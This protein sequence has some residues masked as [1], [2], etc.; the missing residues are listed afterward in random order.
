MLGRE[1]DPG[2][3]GAWPPE[4]FVGTTGWGVGS[5]PQRTG[6]RS[7]LGGKKVK[8]RKGEPHFTDEQTGLQRG[9][10]MTSSWGWYL[11]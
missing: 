5:K 10:D 6:T 9:G 7:A 1:A 3:E 2:R 11:G 8:G 4:T